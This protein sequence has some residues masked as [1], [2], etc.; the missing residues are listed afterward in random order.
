MDWSS[1]KWTIPTSEVLRKQEDF[2]KSSKRPST[3]ASAKRPRSIS[4]D[5]STSNSKKI[6][7]QSKDRCKIVDERL[8]NKDIVEEIFRKVSRPNQTSIPLTA[9]CNHLYNDIDCSYSNIGKQ[10]FQ[11][12]ITALINDKHMEDPEYCVC[13][14]GQNPNTVKF[15]KLR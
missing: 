8:K 1:F 2:I 10:L 12:T 3:A 5:E 6:R 4:Y 13:D 14:A 9:F 7:I 15:V 11:S